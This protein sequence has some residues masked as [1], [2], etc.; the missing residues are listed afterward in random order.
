MAPSSL[1]AP[2]SASR[3]TLV[4]SL[5]SASTT[6]GSMLNG[7]QETPRRTELADLLA[8]ANQS[9]A[10]LVRAYGYFEQAMHLELDPVRVE[11]IVRV[12]GAQLR[13]RALDTPLIFS[14]LALDIS[15]SGCTSLLRTYLGVPNGIDA[16]LPRAAPPSGQASRFLQPQLPPPDQPIPPAFAQETTFANPNDLA[17]LIKWA[18]SRI[19]RVI[20]IPG[21]AAPRPSLTAVDS[22]STTTGIDPP[23]EQQTLYVQQRGFLSLDLYLQWRAVERRTY[24]ILI[25][26]LSV[27]GIVWVGN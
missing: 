27:V 26:G 25:K 5:S 20:A 21:P 3:L 23:V 22:A 18:L 16:F 2:P 9:A 19:G 24:P 6:H 1:P 7:G 8:V 13:Q 12:C 10:A 17:A 4:P 15:P 14:S 11:A